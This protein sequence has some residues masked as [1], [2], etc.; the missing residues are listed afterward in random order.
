[1]L[2]SEEKQLVNLEKYK[3]T[4]NIEKGKVDQSLK[5]I[6]ECLIE[7]KRMLPKS[8]W[9]S[10]LENNVDFTVNTANRYIRSVKIQDN[11]SNMIPDKKANIENLNIWS[12]IEIGKLKR[13]EQKEFIENHD[14]E[15]MSVR[16]IALKVNK[17]KKCDNA[18]KQDS[19][20]KSI[21]LKQNIVKNDDKTIDDIYNETVK[22][23]TELLNRAGSDESIERTLIGRYQANEITHQ[24]ISDVIAKYKIKL[25][26]FYYKELLDEYIK[27]NDWDLWSRYIHYVFEVDKDTETYYGIFAKE[28]AWK[29]AI[30]CFDIEDEGCVDWCKSNHIDNKEF[31]LAVAY[32]ECDSYLCIYKRYK[33]VGAYIHYDISD[34][35]KLCKYDSSLDYKQIKELYYQ[36]N[37]NIDA[38]QKREDLRNEKRKAEYEERQ[39]QQEKYDDALRTWRE[40]YQPL[41]MGKWTFE[42]IWNDKGEIKD[43]QKWREMTEFVSNERKKSYGNTFNSFFGGSSGRNNIIV[44]EEDKPI[45]KRLYRILAKNCHPDI[46]KDDGQAMK[47]VNE[48]KEQWGI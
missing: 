44:N 16:D 35:E 34:I 47:L 36:L 3:N 10:W 27:D 6:S 41:V 33:I 39:A 48:L 19:G 38:Y 26:I 8:E 15:S 28:L 42:D 32:I 23:N 7:V 12:L 17:I 14:T 24:Q 46:I 1:M 2:T 29:E 21:K 13:E 45:Y 43:F 37:I 30:K 25:P 9:S 31:Q 18:Q 11:L 20:E 5:K 4:I 22:L 40:F